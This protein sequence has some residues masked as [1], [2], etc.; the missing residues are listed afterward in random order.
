MRYCALA[1]AALLS[2]QDKTPKSLREVMEESIQKQRESVRKQVRSAQPADP[3]WFTVPWGQED[4]S[5]NK[6][7]DSLIRDAASRE[8]LPESLLRSVIEKESAF[9]PR[10]VS[11][12]GA[13]GLMQL[14][15]DTAA[16][17]GVADPFD[18]AQNVNAGA[19][20]LAQL[21]ARYHG[22]MKLALAAYNAGPSAVDKYNGVPP[23]SETL[24][25]VARILTIR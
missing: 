4:L 12:K 1:L 24:D 3:G 9:N 7:L 8:S 25:Y 17:F 5:Q 6:P 23:Y 20:Y 11:A 21:L 14:M 18:A 19:K 22:D 13:L 16:A 2:A 10:A 15:P